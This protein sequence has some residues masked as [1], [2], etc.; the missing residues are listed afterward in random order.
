M[1][2]H[3]LQSV[4]L[5]TLK[6]TEAFPSSVQASSATTN[7]E[8]SCELLPSVVQVVADF[9]S[10][11]SDEDIDTVRNEVV[12]I[13]FK[14]NH[15]D[16]DIGEIG[17]GSE[18]LPSVG[19]PVLETSDHIAAGKPK[20]VC[21]PPEDNFPASLSDHSKA[22]AVSTKGGKSLFPVKLSAKSGCASAKNKNNLPSLK[23]KEFSC[24]KCGKTF[25][26]AWCKKGTCC[27]CCHVLH[28]RLTLCVFEKD[29]QHVNDTH[30]R[31]F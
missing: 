29:V 4:T 3:Q 5:S 7:A 11:S 21:Q 1:L 15:G 28:S 8:K 9:E 19:L 13:I 17:D 24:D 30:Q 16:I 12:D 27:S 18:I 25:D 26:H 6:P 22:S 14:E 23:S 10:I 2:Q 31:W 20:D